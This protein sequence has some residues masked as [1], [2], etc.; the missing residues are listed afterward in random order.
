[1]SATSTLSPKQLRWLLTLVALLVLV[2]IYQL[3]PARSAAAIPVSTDSINVQQQRLARLRDTAATVP[4]KQEIL[5]RVSAELTAREN[6]LIRADSAAQAQAQLS[7]ILRQ[8]AGSE[9]LELR[10]IELG[11][12]A[13]FG[14]A[15]GAVA[16]TVQFESH[17]EQLLNFMAAIAS[18]P[19]LIAT[20][21]LRILAANQSDK[22][23]NVRLTATAVVPKNLL[24]VKATTPGAKGGSPF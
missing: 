4:A 3:W 9:G 13:P 15:Y 17:I 22:L 14:D 23:V 7:T 11:G 6:G 5:T 18:R 2:L 10:A 8:V 20:R 12:V 16:V 19:E 21:D 1:M 24:P